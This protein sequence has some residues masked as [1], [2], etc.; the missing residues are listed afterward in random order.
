MASPSPTPPPALI[1]PSTSL[2]LDYLLYL[3]HTTTYL[4]LLREVSAQNV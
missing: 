2:C 4:T 1:P 3:G